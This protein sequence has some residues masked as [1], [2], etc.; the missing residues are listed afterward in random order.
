[1]AFHLY[2]EEQEDMISLA[3]Q[4]GEKAIDPVIAEY[5][6]KGVFPED[7]IKSGLEMGFQ[8]LDFPE[9]WGGAGLSS[10]TACVTFEELA[11]HDTGVACAFSVTSTAIAPVMRFGTD[12]QKMMV[13]QKI[14][15]EGG[16]ASFCLTEPGAGSDSGASKTTAKLE[17]NHYILNGNKVFITNGAY[18][19]LYLI[20]ASTDKSKGNKGLTA[21]LVKRDIEGLSV[22]KEENKCGFRTSNTVEVVLDNVRVPTSAVVGGEGNGFKMAMYALDHGRP[23]IGAI[24]V[25]LAQRALKEATDYVKER[26]Q[27]GRSI[28]D[29]QGIQWMLADMEIQI[30]ASRCLV[31]HVAKLIDADKN[32][33]VNGSVAKCFA[34]DTAMKVCT[35]ALQLFGGYGY[36]K[37]YPM[38][39]LFRDA[40]IFQIVEGTNQIQKIVIAKDLLR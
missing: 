35:D 30:E 14:F 7:I 40:K 6:E 22:G 18:A 36:I 25:G 29:N 12:E 10:M 2:T 21:F 9:K 13:R 38:E 16:L 26:R 31:Y 4:Y 20:I 28:S 17:G 27:F 5:D 11:K 19:E 39:K 3:R 1:M 23:Y 24:A 8:A 15:E 37:E 32:I 33:T 34:T